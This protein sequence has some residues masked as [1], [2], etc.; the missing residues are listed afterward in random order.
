MT[1]PI[2]DEDNLN[3]S[4]LVLRL[5]FG[6]NR[7]LFMGDAEKENE[8]AISWSQI[9]VLKVGHHG[10]N[11]SSTERF[12]EQIQPKYAVIM[13]GKD[14][15]YKLPKQETIDKLNHIGTMVYRTDENGT[16]QMKSDGNTI[17]IKTSK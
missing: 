4:S 13:V 3:L 12:L 5:E 2:L 6:N 11:T 8:E 9:D 17:E 14:N 1:E 16:V 7:F 15:S 10:S